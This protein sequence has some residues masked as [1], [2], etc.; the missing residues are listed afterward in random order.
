MDIC[1]A[2]SIAKT[3]NAYKSSLR[4]MESLHEALEV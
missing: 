1:I 4:S 3:F 2:I